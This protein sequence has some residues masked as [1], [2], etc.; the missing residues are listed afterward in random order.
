MRACVFPS[1]FLW[2][3]LLPELPILLRSID[4]FFFLSPT[5]AGGFFMDA[6]LLFPS[7]VYVFLSS[8]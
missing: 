1:S 8:L 4:I 7:E 3:W 5:Q 2:L 6:F